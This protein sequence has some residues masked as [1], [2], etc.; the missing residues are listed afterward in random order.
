MTPLKARHVLWEADGDVYQKG[1]TLALTDTTHDGEHSYAMTTENEPRESYET[2]SNRICRDGIEETRR[3]DHQTKRRRT[4]PMS[5]R[6]DD[7]VAMHGQVLTG[8]DGRDGGRMP[9]EI[10]FRQETLTHHLFFF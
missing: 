1:P 4:H 2:K 7:D 10:S 5:S 6:E 3:R 9:Q 8:W